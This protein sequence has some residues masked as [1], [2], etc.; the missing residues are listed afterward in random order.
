MKKTLKI[1]SLLLCLLVLV[2]VFAVV[3]S[4]ETATQTGHNYDVY[5]VDASGNESSVNIKSDNLYAWLD[6]DTFKSL[7]FVASAATQYNV[8]VSFTSGGGSGNYRITKI[9]LNGEGLTYND[10]R[11]GVY[12][13]RRIISQ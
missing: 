4:A 3:S 1:A 2:G 10:E 7:G 12:N 5:Y 13:P 6:D 8:P 9:V 11:K